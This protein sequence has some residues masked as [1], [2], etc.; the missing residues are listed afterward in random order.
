MIYSKELE[1]M[2]QV[3]K[4]VDHGPAPIP[5]EGKWVKSKEIKDIIDEDH[6]ANTTCHFCGSEYHF[7]EEELTNLYNDANDWLITPPIKFTDVNSIYEISLDAAASA[8]QYTEAFEVY[9]GATASPDTMVK[10]FGR[11][12]INH[13][14]FKTYSDIFVVRTHKIE[15]CRISRITVE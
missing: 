8:G 12:D 4:G 15:K 3:K 14:Y 6:Q 13:S 10:I 9:I 11:D 5:E 7:S 1:G 2:C